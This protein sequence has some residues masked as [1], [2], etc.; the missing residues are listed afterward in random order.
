VGEREDRVKQE[1]LDWAVKNWPGLSE[2]EASKLLSE[3][4]KILIMA[5]LEHGTA[6]DLKAAFTTMLNLKFR[7]SSA[8]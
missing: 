2:A 8:N 7:P 1:L 6:A 5:G 3:L 4:A